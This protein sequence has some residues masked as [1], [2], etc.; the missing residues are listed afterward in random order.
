MT[1]T[2]NENVPG[3]TAHTIVVRDQYGPLEFVGETIADLSWTYD[4]AARFGH[5]RWTDITLYRVLDD[6]SEY[7]YAIQIMGR[8]VLYHKTGGACHIGITMPV[9]VLAKDDE[10]YQAL[11]ACP[12]CQ[13]V[14]LSKMQDSE[15]V[16]VEENLPTLHRC[17][18]AAEVIDVMYTRSK[19]EKRSG[20][21]MK[22]LQTASTVD[23]DIADAMMKTR[24]L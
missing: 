7:A 18:D 8:S 15:T 24:K 19:R 9:S 14:D 20:L 17:R 16:A 2:S 23:E 5:D 1:V 6:T 12:K 13:P 10:R 21:S 11:K 22:L 3:S 4:A